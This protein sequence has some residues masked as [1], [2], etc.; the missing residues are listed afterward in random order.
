MTWRE[1]PIMDAWNR[2]EVGRAPYCAHDALHEFCGFL[3]WLLAPAAVT[4]VPARSRAL[5]GRAS[6]ERGGDIENRG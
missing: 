2:E 6:G 4:V 3:R 1:Y 5:G